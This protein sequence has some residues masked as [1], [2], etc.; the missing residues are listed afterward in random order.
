MMQLQKLPS[1]QIW[2]DISAFPDIN[3]IDT[4]SDNCNICNDIDIDHNAKPILDITLPYAVYYRM[5][6]TSKN[7]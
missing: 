7:P 5:P 3:Y 2:N 6:Y 4:L 1:V